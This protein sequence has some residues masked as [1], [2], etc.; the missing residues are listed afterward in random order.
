MQLKKALNDV[1]FQ[2][3]SKN[4]SLVRDSMARGAEFQISIDKKKTESVNRG[5]HVQ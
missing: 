5:L 3:P 4:S 2:S 1:S